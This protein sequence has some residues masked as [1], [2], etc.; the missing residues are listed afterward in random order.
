MSRPISLV[1]RD[2]ESQI[3]IAI[4]DSQL[5]PCIVKA[6]LNG[7]YQQVIRAAQAEIAQAEKEYTEEGKKNAE[8]N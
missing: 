5:P 4:S 6:V 7:L 2:L 3:N 1:I 8:S